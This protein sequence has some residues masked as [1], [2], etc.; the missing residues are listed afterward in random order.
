LH[1]YINI[2][3]IKYFENK[4]T[5]QYIIIKRL[6]NQYT[7]TYNPE[8]LKNIKN[9]K[10]KRPSNVERQTYLNNTYLLNGDSKIQ[11]GLNI[12]SSDMKRPQVLAQTTI[13]IKTFNHNR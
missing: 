1:A 5:L 4:K 13:P 12:C 3:K 9:C 11:K 7:H 10:G 8:Q 2:N 6:T